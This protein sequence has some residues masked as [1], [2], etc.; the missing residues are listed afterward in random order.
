MVDVLQLLLHVNHVTIDAAQA[1]LE[2]LTRRMFTRI[3]T[4]LA[5]TLKSEDLDVVQVAALYLVDDR[6]AL[7]IGD[8]AAAVDRSLTAVSRPIDDLVQRG[9]LLRAEDPND[10]RARVL[11]LS[12]KGRK[13]L[14]RAG[15]D[16]VRTMVEATASIPGNAVALL[17]DALARARASFVEK[18]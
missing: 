11:T 8:V 18:E 14:A 10:R 17:G 13:F 7:R 6:G 15:T 4:A 2:A 1:P 16:R 3:I 5:R 12:A 9:L